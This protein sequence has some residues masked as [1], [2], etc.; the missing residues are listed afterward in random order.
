MISSSI[1][2]KII[3]ILFFYNISIWKKHEELMMFV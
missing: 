1:M 3:Q 2:K